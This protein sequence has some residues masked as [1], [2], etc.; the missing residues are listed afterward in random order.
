M[1]KVHKNKNKNLHLERIIYFHIY[2]ILLAKKKH[3]FYLSISIGRIPMQRFVI[4][5]SIFTFIKV[6]AL[7]LGENLRVM[8]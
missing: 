8:N 5:M 3:R 6:V 1:S 2:K 4:L 7:L